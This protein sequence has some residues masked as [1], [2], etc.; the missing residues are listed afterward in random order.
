[1]NNTFFDLLKRVSNL[2]WST[3]DPEPRTFE[4]ILLS[5]KIAFQQAMMT[6]WNDRVYPFQIFV[7]YKHVGAGENT[8]KGPTGALEDITLDGQTLTCVG[9]DAAFDDKK[10]RPQFYKFETTNEFDKITLYPT[11]DQPYIIGQRYKKMLMAKT[12]DGTEKFNLEQTDDKINILH[13]I[14]LELFANAVILLTQCNLIQDEQD[15]NFT[16][17]KIAYLDA[18]DKLKNYSPLRQDKKIVM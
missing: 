1:M 11:P 12:K 2:K 8:F 18:L 4:D 10:G 15:E 17:Y 16:P 3:N 13:P 9:E 6:V 5:S 7:D 14:Y